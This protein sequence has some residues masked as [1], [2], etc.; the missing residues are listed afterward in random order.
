[1]VLREQGNL[2]GEVLVKRNT[3]EQMMR[4]GGDHRPRPN[5]GGVEEKGLN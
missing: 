2:V 3:W 1:M 5:G 4:G